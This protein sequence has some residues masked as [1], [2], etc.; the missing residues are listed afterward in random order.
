VR[1][2]S[3]ELLNTTHVVNEVMCFALL[4]N[5]DSMV[6]I[7]FVN[8][9]IRIWDLQA[10]AEL[11]QLIGHTML[12]NRIIKLKDNKTIASASDDRTIRIWKHKNA[13]L[14]KN[15]TGHTKEVND[16]VQLS[17]GDLVSCSSD[18]TIRI[19]KLKTGKIRKNLSRV[20]E[21]AIYRLLIIENNNADL[22]VSSSFD[23]KICVLNVT[24]RKAIKTISDDTNFINCLLLLNNGQL[25]SGE[26]DSL[27]KIWNMETNRLVDRLEGHVDIVCALINLNMS[28]IASGSKDK[29]I[30]IWNYESSA[31]VQTLIGHSSTVL[32]FILLG[33][34]NLASASLDATIK[35]WNLPAIFKYPNRSNLIPYRDW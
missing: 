17:N 19:W 2:S 20:H 22:L 21:D 8:P 7:G 32:G 33:D 30:K 34:G 3:S 18:K 27:V 28:H 15:L 35:M 13:K 14:L 10:K 11:S 1:E 31:L 6:V 24:S 9:I 25:A 5:N 4:N 29:T 16:L 23:R 26:E 12:V